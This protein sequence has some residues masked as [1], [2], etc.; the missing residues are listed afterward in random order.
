MLFFRKSRRPKVRLP[1]TADFWLRLRGVD[2][3]ARLYL[4]AVSYEPR[5]GWVMVDGKRGFTAEVT[6]IT[7]KAGRLFSIVL[8]ISVVRVSPHQVP[9]AV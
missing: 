2:L 1:W 5:S 9:I 6:E 8:V 3:I 7:E 4:K